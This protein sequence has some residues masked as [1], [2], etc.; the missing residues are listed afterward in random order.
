[1]TSGV[2]GLGGCAATAYN[3][4]TG[5]FW[6]GTH[7]AGIIAAIDNATGV[8]GIAPKATIVPVK[9]LHGGSGSFGAV[10]AAVLY[11]GDHSATGGRAD[12]INMSLGAVFPKNDAW[13]R[14]SCA[15]RSRK[16]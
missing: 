4:D 9:A 1:M 16:P 5:T 7:V 14:A 8:I 12:I 11:A 13:M 10:V 6:H 2:P 15:T 3:C